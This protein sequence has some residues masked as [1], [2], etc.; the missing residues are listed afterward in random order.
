MAEKANKKSKIKLGGNYRVV[1]PIKKQNPI[2]LTSEAKDEDT[3]YYEETNSVLL[4]V[5]IFILVNILIELGLNYAIYIKKQEKDA[6]R[7]K[8]ASFKNR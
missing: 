8:M 5:L 6:E 1:Q 2:I 7:E 3:T 4:I